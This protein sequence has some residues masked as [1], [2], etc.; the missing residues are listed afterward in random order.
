MALLN[1][2]HLCQQSVHQVT[3][4]LRFVGFFVRSQPQL[5]ELLVGYVIEAE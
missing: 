4:V 1:A 3:V 5:D 2:N